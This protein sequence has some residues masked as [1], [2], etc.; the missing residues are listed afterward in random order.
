MVSGL[1]VQGIGLHHLQGLARC[2]QREHPVLGGHI[3][4]DQADHAGVQANFGAGFRGQAQLASPRLLQGHLGHIAEFDQVFA[5]P[6]V[7]LLL[8]GDRL[9]QR[10]PGHQFGRQQDL[11]EPEPGDLGP[12]HRFLHIC[13]LICTAHQ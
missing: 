4:R 6:A 3:F 13:H 9:W 10:L 11:A 8:Q 1:E 2:L 7:L 5:Q 12:V